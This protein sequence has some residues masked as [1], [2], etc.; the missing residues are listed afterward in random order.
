MMRS[1][2]CLRRYRATRVG[3]K[4]DRGYAELIKEFAMNVA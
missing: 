2:I 3:A 1:T 4:P